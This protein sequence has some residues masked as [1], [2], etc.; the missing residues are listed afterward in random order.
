RLDRERAQHPDL[1]QGPV[2]IHPGPAEPDVAEDVA[3]LLHDQARPPVMTEPGPDVGDPQPVVLPLL[4]ERRR[5]HPEHV[6][7]VD[8]LLGAD[9]VARR[10]IHATQPRTRSYGATHGYRVP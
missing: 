5:D 10:G 3:S 9:L 4:A 7:T 1:D 8:R 6:V 2:G